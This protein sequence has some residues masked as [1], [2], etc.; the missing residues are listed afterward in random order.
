MTTVALS[1]LAAAGGRFLGMVCRYSETRRHGQGDLLFNCIDMIL[2]VIV[3]KALFDLT[4]TEREPTDAE[5]QLLP[6]MG[7]YF[8]SVPISAAITHLFYRNTDFLADW[9]Y[10]MVY[11]TFSFVAVDTVKYLVNGQHT[12]AWFRP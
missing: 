2:S 11:S 8:V 12:L 7:R 1:V 10:G 5:K 3:T 9:R 6:T 4:K